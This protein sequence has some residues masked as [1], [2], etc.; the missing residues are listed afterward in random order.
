MGSL[1]TFAL[2]TAI[3]V[4]TWQNA[5]PPPDRPAADRTNNGLL[6]QFN[7]LFGGRSNSAPA[8]PPRGGSMP[9]PPNMP[10]APPPEFGASSAASPSPGAPAVP[11]F[12]AA[13]A[14]FSAA[15]PPAPAASTLPLAMSPA[16]QHA[17]Q[18]TVRLRVEDAHGQSVAT[19]TI[20]D[21]YGAEALVVTC[22]HVF[23]ESG[24]RGKVMVELFA[25]GATAALP[26]QVLD[27]DLYRDI[28]LVVIRPNVAV[29]PAR[30][31][32]PQHALERGHTVFSIGC[33]RGD[34]PQVMASQIVGV[35]KYVGPPNYVATGAPTEGRSG[36][37]L[38]NDDG[39][40]VGVCNAADP[41]DNEGLY[42][43]LPTLHWQLDQV[44]QARIYGGKNGPGAN[45]ASAIAATPATGAQPPAAA[46]ES[47]VPASA[48][49]AA[50]AGVDPVLMLA[51]EHRDA[52]AI[53]IWRSSTNPQGRP[54]V[55][56]IERL[57]PDMR[58]QLN[59]SSAVAAGGA[60]TLSPA[61]APVPMNGQP[62]FAQNGAPVGR[63]PPGMAP[64]GMAQPGMGRPGAAPADRAP[65]LRAQTP[66]ASLFGR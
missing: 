56:R 53:I 37:G 40:L 66:K 13:P 9:P 34:R 63:M 54:E 18:A 19:G 28:G 29:K 23:R 32:T 49:S 57:T 21:M 25:P 12:S 44:G 51:Q 7:S 36:G 38:F 60:R 20:V 27:Y 6:P 61:P 47:A 46:R 58:D 17:L 41:A 10:P 43:A 59:R 14:G 50:P 65:V 2:W 31:G 64:Q 11:A 33:D 24:G 15:P 3:A 42:A 30:V 8:A 26:G 4:P 5:P 45:G 16:M 55:V 52:E 22:G 1:T 62:A 39:V 48:M 35:N